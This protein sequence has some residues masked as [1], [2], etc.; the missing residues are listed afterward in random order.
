MNEW[1]QSQRQSVNLLD[2]IQTRRRK[3]KLSDDNCQENKLWL[4][5]HIFEGKDL[6]TK[7]RENNWF[8]FKNL[9]SATIKWMSTSSTNL[10]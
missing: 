5:G 3:K 8:K 6:E 9:R 10:F 4:D 1:N 7:R 2:L